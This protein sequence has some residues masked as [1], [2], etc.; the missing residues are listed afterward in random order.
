MSAAFPMS[1]W[2]PP[3]LVERAV[4]RA[5]V[6]PRL[7]MTHGDRDHV[8]PFEETRRIVDRLASSGAPIELEVVPGV[9]HRFTDVM[10]RDL[11]RWIDESLAACRAAR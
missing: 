9:G 11:A 4:E 1:A 10:K 2:L 8:V 5:S 7:R 3:E 6:L